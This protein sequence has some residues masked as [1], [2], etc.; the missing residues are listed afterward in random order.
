MDHVFDHLIELKKNER[1]IIVHIY[2]IRDR[3][4]PSDSVIRAFG[5]KTGFEVRYPPFF[6][7]VHAHYRTRSTGI[8]SS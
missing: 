3:P 8:I 6:N 2:L 7:V 1:M 5:R 4:V